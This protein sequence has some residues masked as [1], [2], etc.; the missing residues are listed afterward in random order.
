VI[1]ANLPSCGRG[2]IFKM[3][4]IS[5]FARGKQT[6]DLNILIIYRFLFITLAHA[7]S[8]ATGSK[9]TNI[10]ASGTMATSFSE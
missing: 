4:V 8:I 1:Y 7:L 9:E 3:I 5:I 10:S 2:K 6:A